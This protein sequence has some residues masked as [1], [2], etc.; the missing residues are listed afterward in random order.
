MN[1]RS[2]RILPLIAVAFALIALSSTAFGQC[3]VSNAGR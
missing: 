1:R 3:G 2:L